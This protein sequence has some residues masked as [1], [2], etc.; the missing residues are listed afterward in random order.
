MGKSGGGGDQVFEVVELGSGCRGPLEGG[1]L[2]GG[3]DK[4]KEMD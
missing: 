2:G 1:M 4:G 3:F